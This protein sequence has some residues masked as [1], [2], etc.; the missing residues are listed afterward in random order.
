MSECR[1]RCDGRTWRF[2]PTRPPE[3]EMTPL[4]P[5]RDPLVTLPSEPWKHF[6]EKRRS[7][8]PKRLEPKWL[9]KRWKWALAKGKTVCCLLF[10]RP[11]KSSVRTQTINI[12]MY[13]YIYIYIDMYTYMYMYMYIYIYI[14]ILVLLYIVRRAKYQKIGLVWDTIKHMLTC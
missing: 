4:T 11:Q 1:C 9:R 6:S 2:R 13:I 10:A 3:E 8:K 14:Y 7:E 12:C 5:R